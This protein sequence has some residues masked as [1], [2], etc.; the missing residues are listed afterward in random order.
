MTG[1][2]LAGYRFGP[3]LLN[4]DRL[5]LQQDGADIELRPK[6]FDVLRMLVEQNGRVVSKDELVAAVWPHVIV[7]DDALA[8]CVRDIRKALDDDG[9]RFVRTVP[10]R[11]YE[12]VC[13]VTPVGAITM[14]AATAGT[15]TRSTGWPPRTAPSIAIAAVI[16][17]AA[18]MAIWQSGV[19]GRQMPQASGAQL[20]I[21]VLPFAAN[22]D[23]TWHGDG[24]AEDITTAV[25]RFRNLTVI[26]RTSSFRFRDAG[27]D[28]VSVGDDL[29]ASYLLT[30]SV[31]R[32]GDKVRI[33]AQLV[34][35]KSGA[36]RWTESY[37]RSFADV[38][39]IQ[40]EVVDSVAAQ[41][42]VHAVTDAAAKLSGPPASMR[43]YELALRARASYRQ[44]S[45]D[46]SLE[47]WRL[48]EQAI[49]LDPNYAPSWETLAAAKLQFY[50]QPYG[51]N[52]HSPE[53]LKEARE[54]A[55]RAVALDGNFAT[56]H[57]MLAFT[58]M[59]SRQYEESIQSVKK[60]V[61]LNPNDWVGQGIYANILMFSG[62]YREAVEA[63]DQAMRFDPYAPALNLALK[64]MPLIML[65]EFDHALR[66][67]R[68]CAERA[69]RL[70]ACWL[71]R[72]VAESQLGMDDEV[73][74]T[75]A[76]M[77][78]IYPAFTISRH[79]HAVPFRDKKEEERL[80]AYLRTAGLP[81]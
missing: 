67:T 38:F 68:S 75:L 45:R 71:Y 17:V 35:A 72:A 65:G 56:A 55:Q 12:F 50:I 29:G 39:D 28:P 1:H 73:A 78:E 62:R 32:A 66:L 76:T 19:F 5:R 59:W 42:V 37:D 27:A 24:I 22:P 10:R 31:R 40:Q 80:A 21:A 34:D 69:P 30:G 49:A 33:T 48:A 46:S 61:A 2:R 41:L 26:A 51:P 63:F 23:E 44:F 57:A 52:Q 74:R 60:A 14:P 7:N 13:S 25:S 43:A 79:M 15:E 20:S 58:Q 77:H 4:L 9:E 11:G 16:V 18:A 64:S 36:S 54:A 3:Y 8:Q 81:D 53:I 47:A 6:A 70:F